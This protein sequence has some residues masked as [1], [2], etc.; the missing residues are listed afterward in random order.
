MDFHLQRVDVDDPRAVELRGIL[1]ADLDER[2]RE[3]DADDPPGMA[4]ERAEALAV[5]ADQVVA[6]FLAVDADGTALGHVM[7]RRLDE[8]WELK[9]LIVTATARRRG[10]GRALTDAVV[11]RAAEGGARRV[12]LQSG[13]MQP[14]SLA[15]YV[16]AGFTPIPV[17]EPYIATM[18]ESLC[19]ERVL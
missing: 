8:E 4:E 13:R 6:T 5:H 1:D 3:A 15:L 9:R 18:P 11:A 19:F 12:I 7:L 10:V 2:Y 14:E 17:Y 16:A